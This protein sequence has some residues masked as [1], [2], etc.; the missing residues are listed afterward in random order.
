M[1]AAGERGDGRAP[2]R[3]R[4]AKLR[5]AAEALANPA[6]KKAY[7]ESR[8]AWRP[9]SG[10]LPNYYGQLG[11][12][13]HATPDEV[14]EAVTAA[15]LALG[16]VR[17]PEART[18]DGVIREAYWVLRDPARRALYDAARQRSDR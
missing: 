14:A 12:R 7:D 3:R 9:A 4:A 13:Q 6:R 18:K 15:H 10:G 2:D 1:R 5:A 11:I 17:S 16:K 8:P